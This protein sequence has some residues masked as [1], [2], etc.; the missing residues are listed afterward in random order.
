[1]SGYPIPA[2]EHEAELEVRRSRFVARVGHADSAEAAKAF[3]G[4]IQERFADATHNCWAFQA[5]PPGD[6]RAIGCS[7]DG[8]PHGTAGRPMLNVLLHAPV[9]EVVVVVTRYFGGVK[10]GTGGLA[11]AYAD[12]VS[13]ALEGLPVVNK[14]NRTPWRLVVDYRLWPEFERRL[15]QHRGE[16]VQVDYAEKVSASVAIPETETQALFAWLS[17]ASQGQVICEPE[18]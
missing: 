14:E 9:G 18:D 4:K 2:G 10:L 15:A 8:E 11:R 13:L 12:A 7:D 6:T 16:I 17:D 5:G 3:I 1:V